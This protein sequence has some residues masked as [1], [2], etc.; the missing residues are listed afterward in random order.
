[1]VKLYLNDSKEYELNKKK[2][3]KL[4]RK[5]PFYALWKT[6]T[7]HKEYFREYNFDHM[8]ERFIRGQ[9]PFGLQSHIELDELKEL[10][11]YI[12]KEDNKFNYQFGIG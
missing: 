6:N 2:I 1:M 11:E 10:K 3:H 12:L 8:L 9:T 4:F 5:S 7:T